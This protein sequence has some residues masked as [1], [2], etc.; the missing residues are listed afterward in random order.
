MLKVEWIPAETPPTSNSEVWL[1]VRDSDDVEFAMIGRFSTREGAPGN[2]VD[3]RWW[4]LE[5]GDTVLAW[6]PFERPE[7]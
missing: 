6:A 2:W 4:R 7:V 5:K 1:K 3:F